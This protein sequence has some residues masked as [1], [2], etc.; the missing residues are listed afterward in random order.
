MINISQKVKILKKIKKTAGL[1]S[2][3]IKEIVAELGYNPIKHDFC[4]LS[5]PYATNLVV[6]FFKE[7]F[8]KKKSI[9]NILESYPANYT[10]V[11]KRISLFEG[12]DSK[13]MVVGNGAMQAIEWVCEG[14]G[15]KN[16]LIPIPTYSSYY[17]LLNNKHT[18]TSNFWLSKNLTA[19]NLLKI[20]EKKNCDSI[21]LIYPNNP[22][23]EIMELK[24]LNKL[25]TLLG[26]KKLIIDESF[27]HFIDSY[28]KYSTFRN[29]I[30]SKN[31]TFIKSMSKDFGIAG[32]RLG[33]L[34]TRD[35][36]LIEFSKRKTTWNLNNFS[37]L[38]SDLLATS[39]FKKKYQLARKMFFQSR[40]E[41]MSDLSKI[42]NIK[43][44]LTQA[45]FFLIKY[46][47][48]KR[49]DLVYEMLLNDGIYV[50]TMSDKVG[51]DN[52]YIRVAVRKIS[53]N[54][55]FVNTLKKYVS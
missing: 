18:F 5:N 6:D 44:F 28:E 17:E 1:H 30:V 8:S 51:L 49:P 3:S 15:I 38:F 36:N 47:K 21:L 12:L 31:I 54:K 34:Y 25:V 23:G 43:V 7:F 55:F 29:K 2:P 22:T 19:K 37:V 10:Y 40:N 33:Y 35:K 9:F 50:R 42:S 41:L 39:I 20:A 16:L 14:W 13:F 11:A 27:S 32:I 46:D 26:N 52:S 45:N 24:E 4:F 53:E 48:I